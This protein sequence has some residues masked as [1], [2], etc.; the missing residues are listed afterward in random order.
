MITIDDI[1]SLPYLNANKQRKVAI[2]LGGCSGIGWYTVLHLYL[3]GYTVYITGRSKSRVIKCINE[4]KQEAIKI[5][6]KY[7]I[8]QANHR[9]VGDL[10]YL[11]IDL[12]NLQSVVQAA[13]H[14]IQQEPRLHF[15]INNICINS[16]PYMETE[17][18]LE[19]HL[20]IN[21][22]APFLLV[23]CLLPL[24]ESSSEGSSSGTSEVSRIIYTS[25]ISHYLQ[26]QYFSMNNQFDYS[27]QILFNWL[28]YSKA[29]L[30]GIHLI[31]MMALRNPKILSV[32]VDPGF[33]MN[34]NIF[35]Y[36]TRLPIVGIIFWC[37]FQL[38]GWFFGITIEQASFALIKA[39]LDPNLNLELHNGK[40]L[41]YNG[42]ECQGSAVGN[43][44][45]Y[46][47]RTWIWTV[48]QLEEK[49]INIPQ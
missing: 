40:I 35:S 29:K 16:L 14:L 30:S 8:D 32:I 17:D 9:F 13:N 46:A 37:C 20:Q 19:L 24:L 18:G 31:K 25:S 48:N 49:N 11:E 5:R 7:T 41:D 45:D 34:P 47:A 33:V 39:C 2:I 42:Q 38:F 21:Y 26:F 12:S 43:N 28:R 6:L 44:M 1:H 3:H 22:I 23:M 10:K 27:P 36:L 4:L 15:V